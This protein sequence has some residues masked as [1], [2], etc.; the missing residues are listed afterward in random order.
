M[1]SLSSHTLPNLWQ[2]SPPSEPVSQLVYASN[3]LGSDPRITNFGGGNTSVKVWETDPLTGEEVEVLWVKGS[4]GDLGSSSKAGFASLYLSK[5]VRLED[6][7]RNGRKKKGELDEDQIVPLFG[8]C[9]FGE[10]RAAPSIDTPLHAFVP[11]PCV[12]H[13]H[14]DAVIA[15]AA[16][17]DAENLMKLIYGGRMGYLPWKRPGIELGLMLRDLIAEN[18]TINSALM[19]QHGFICWEDSWEKC[20]ALTLDLVNEAQAFID[21]REDAHAFGQLAPSKSPTFN[22]AQLVEFLPK[23][24]GR[25]SFHGQRLIA[26]FDDSQPVLDFLGREKAVELI[27]LG[28]SCPDHFLRTKI[29]PLVLES[30]EDD[31]VDQKLSEFRAEYGDYYSRCCRVTSPA[32]RNP[33]PSIVLIPGAGMIS[34]GKNAAEARIAGEF[35]RNAINVMKGAETVSKYV[36]LPEQEAFDIE[37]WLLE[38]AKLKRQPPEKE[39]SRQV[40][41]VVGAGPGIGRE[42]AERLLGEGAV[43]IVADRNPHLVE[44]TA[45]ALSSRFGKDVVLGVTLDITDRA[46]VQS[47]LERAVLRFGGIDVLVNIAAVFIPPTPEGTLTDAQ[48]RATFEINVVGSQIVSEE[49]ALVM[50][51]QGTPASIVLV[52]SANAVVAK[53]GSVAYDTSKAAVNHLVR[54]LAIELSPLIRVNAVAPAT[55]VAGSQMFPRDRVIASLTKYEIPFSEDETDEALRDHLAHFYAKRTLLRQPVSPAK[56]ADAAVLLAGSRLSQTTGQ[57]VA[58]DAGLPE[59]FLR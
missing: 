27:P 38:E 48:W 43:V 50:K 22:S 2:T 44:E 20:Y 56:V 37:Y 4:G 39:F 15:I 21:A 32:M 45:A 53:K 3:L 9:A 12:S 31:H 41:M 54:E 55:V 5:V 59:A 49:A 18:P 13:M 1:S 52:S 30:L 58:V 36:A 26:S 17:Q 14:S 23:L 10:N 42:I 34:F 51:R 28:T 29:R 7:Y 8:L 24:R 16:S 40:A 46:S 57:I 35:Y 47:A 6:R 19:G 11:S 25:V 33:N